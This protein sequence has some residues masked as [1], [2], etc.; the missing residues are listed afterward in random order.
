MEHLWSCLVAIAHKAH[1][2]FIAGLYITSGKEALNSHLDLGDLGDNVPYV[3][4]K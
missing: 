1:F 3:F 4:L 2:P